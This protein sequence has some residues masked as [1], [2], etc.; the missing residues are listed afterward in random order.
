MPIKR[1]KPEQ[2][3]LAEGG[4]GSDGAVAGGIQLGASAKSKPSFIATCC[5][6]ATLPTFDFRPGVPKVSRSARGS[7]INYA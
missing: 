6:V 3:T 2:I 5:D 1:Y 7:S 4:T